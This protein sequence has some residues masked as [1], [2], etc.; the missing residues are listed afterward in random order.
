MLLEC[1]ELSN[2]AEEIDQLADSS[3][4]KIKLSKDLCGVEVELLSFGHRFKALLSEHVRLDVRIFK[5]LAALEDSNELVMGVL[6][7]IPK[8]TVFKCGRNFNLR[9]GQG[10]HLSVALQA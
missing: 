6:F 1:L 7:L 9:V 2:R 5:I 10:A 4:E 8:T 3:T